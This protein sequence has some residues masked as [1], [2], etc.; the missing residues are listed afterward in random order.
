MFR[1]LVYSVMLRSS[2]AVIYSLNDS[3][4][5]SMPTLFK[6]DDFAECMSES[7]GTYCMADFVL[8]PDSSK[9]Y[10]MIK[11]YSEYSLKHFNHTQLH[12]GVCVS[13]S[14]KKYYRKSSPPELAKVLEE[15]V[16]ET[17]WRDYK[18]QLSLEKIQN[19]QYANQQTVIDGYDLAV[20]VVYVLIIALNILGSSYDAWLTRKNQKS[21]NPYLLAFSVRRNWQLLTGSSDMERDPRMESLKLFH[22]LRSM[23]MVCVFFSHTVLVMAHGYVENPLF[24]EKSYEDPWKQILYN[25]SLVTHTFFVMSSFLLAY[26]LQIYAEKHTINIMQW[27]RGVLLRWLRLAPAYAVVLA[28]ICTWM[29]HLGTGPMWPSVVDS[30][31]VAC[32]HYWWAH[33]LFINNYIYD[34]PWCLPQTWYLASDT[35]LF[36]LGLLLV[37]VWRSARARAAVLATTFV[38]ALAIVALHT[39]F[40]DLDAV[41]IQK[42]ESYRN[43]Y[44]TDDTFR[45]VYSRGHTNLSTYTMGLAGGFLTYY[46]QRTRKDFTPYKRYR[47]A[48]WALFPLAVAV[49][50]SGGL[51][52]LDGT[53]VPAGL[54]TLYASVY[55]PVFQA[56]VT[57]FIISCIF[58][59][60]S[61]YR[62]IVEWRGFAWTGRV[63]YGAFLVHTMLQRGLV[64]QQARPTYFSDYYVLYILSATIFLAFALASVLFLL[65]EAPAGGL[66][67]AFT[68]PARPARPERRATGAGAAA[69]AASAAAVAPT[70]A[71]PTAAE[72]RAGDAAAEPKPE[73]LR[74]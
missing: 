42:P 21:G 47:V 71:A 59:I 23:T 57:M 54:R 51:F 33:L 32:R 36:A 9:L 55:K 49:I 73:R 44:A 12:R 38:I 14:C 16:N 35:Q 70:A 41:V 53:R 31:A 2:L 5:Y 65:V 72:P 69:A 58:K 37:V 66:V 26:N 68:R 43:L 56:C 22:G 67:R 8:K 1:L 45:L 74:G 11:E 62:G 64:G 61:V 40:Q 50:M 10:N 48:V 17:L 27:P 60:E 13:R 3:D 34:D 46:W 39:Y 52:Y 63:S 28:T 29:R 25:G 30:E 18:L 15:C 6:M 20:A 24:I 7:H 4:Y 19:C